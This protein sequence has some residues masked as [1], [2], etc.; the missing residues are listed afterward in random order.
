MVDSSFLGLA[1]RAVWEMTMGFAMEAFTYRRTFS[2]VSTRPRKTTVYLSS[3][4]MARMASSTFRTSIGRSVLSGSNPYRVHDYAH[5]E[6]RGQPLAGHVAYYQEGPAIVYGY[7]VVVVAGDV[8]QRAV[9]GGRTEFGEFGHFL[10][11][12]GFLGF[13]DEGPLLG[14]GRDVEKARHRDDAVEVELELS[15]EY[16]EGFQFHRTR[17]AGE[18][19]EVVAFADAQ[20]AAAAQVGGVQAVFVVQEGEAF[21]PFPEIPAAAGP[22]FRGRS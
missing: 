8:D 13:R 3:N 9:V 7:D 18:D 4:R 10:G 14:E 16:P 1:P 6:G 15:V 2:P 20:E 5:D 21:R 11:Q 22:G 19:E 12:E 17:R